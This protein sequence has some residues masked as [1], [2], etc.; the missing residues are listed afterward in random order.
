MADKNKKE[1]NPAAA[2]RPKQRMCEIQVPTVIP[3]TGGERSTK[4]V[5]ERTE[6][7]GPGRDRGGA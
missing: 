6:G 4:K 2:G 7:G 3:I 1:N 5:R